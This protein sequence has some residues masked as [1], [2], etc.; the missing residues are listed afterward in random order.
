VKS[1]QIIFDVDARDDLASI[2]SHITEATGAERAH[3]YL[4]RIHQFCAGFDQMPERFPVWRASHPNLRIAVFEKSLSIAF[5]VQ[6][7]RVL[8]LRV[9]G[10]GR[11]R[12]GQLGPKVGS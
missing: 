12:D 2:L 9:L 8:I 5:E 7:D 3:G 10:R 6:E 4:D 11:D 1:Y